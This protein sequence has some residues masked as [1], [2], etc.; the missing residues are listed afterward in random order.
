[1]KYRKIPNLVKFKKARGFGKLLPSQEFLFPMLKAGGHGFCVIMWVLWYS[2]L[3]E[4]VSE[5][6]QSCPTLCNPWTIAYPGSSIQ[7]IFQLRILEWVAIS[8]S[9][10]IL[11]TWS[12]SPRIFMILYEF[13]GFRSRVSQTKIKWVLMLCSPYPKTMARTSDFIRLRCKPFEHFEQITVII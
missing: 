4:W 2:I 11:N 12:K 9:N 5:V 3:N 7:G 6:A 10:S 13:C 1:M 8:F